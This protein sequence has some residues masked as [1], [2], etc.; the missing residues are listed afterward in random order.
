M[1][2]TN[3]EQGHTRADSVPRSVEQQL[4][5]DIARLMDIGVLEEDYSSE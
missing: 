4:C 5:K 2:D 3:F 1:M